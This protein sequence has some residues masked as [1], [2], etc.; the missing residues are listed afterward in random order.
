MPDIFRGSSRKDLSGG[1][2]QGLLGSGGALNKSLG[3]LNK[4][5]GITLKSYL[6]LD[7]F[8]PIAGRY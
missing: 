8:T 6:K 7:P 1:G 4:M 5:K 3:Y 2:G